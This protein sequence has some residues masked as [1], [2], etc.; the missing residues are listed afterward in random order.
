MLQNLP[1][2]DWIMRPE[3]DPVFEKMEALGLSLD[4]LVFP[5]HLPFLEARVRKHPKLKVVIDHGAKPRIADLEFSS[6]AAAIARLAELEQV[7][8]KLSGLP[9]E[10]ADGQRD[11]ELNPYIRHLVT[12]FGPGRL[13]WGSDWPVVN[14]NSSY[15]A[16]FDTAVSL[17]GLAGDDL[18]R[19]YR[20]TAMQ[21][22]SID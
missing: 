19:L 17:S 12:C 5:R 21:F 15:R 3:F 11:A 4:A 7:F 16:W 14:L 20:R 2:D 22:Y 13:M 8:C 9:A 6:W 10:M 1:D 18:D